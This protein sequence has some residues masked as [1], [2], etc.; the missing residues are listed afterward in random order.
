MSS[1]VDPTDTPPGEGYVSFMEYA[2]QHG[3]TYHQVY[4]WVRWGHL[5]GARHGGRWWVRRDAPRPH[6]RRGGWDQGRRLL[7]AWG[8]GATSG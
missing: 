7:I 8:A 6:L 3:A 5:T 4:G 1:R 2:A